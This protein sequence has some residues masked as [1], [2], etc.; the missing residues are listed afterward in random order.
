MNYLSEAMY[1]TEDTENR[2]QNIER[3]QLVVKIARNFIETEKIYTRAHEADYM[4]LGPYDGYIPTEVLFQKMLL[5][6]DIKVEADDTD[7]EAAHK[8]F[9][10]TIDLFVK[11]RVFEYNETKTEVRHSSGPLQDL[12]ENIVSKLL[13]FALEA[14]G[15]GEIRIPFNDTNEKEKRGLIKK[16]I[17]EAKADGVNASYKEGVSYHDNETPEFILK[18]RGCEENTFFEKY[19][20]MMKC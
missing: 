18:F 2:L 4:E 10:Q 19:C 20:K 9:D 13:E 7:E 16:T 17:T 12:I 6:D 11:N 3:L 1:Y 5:L 8:E 15:W 14:P